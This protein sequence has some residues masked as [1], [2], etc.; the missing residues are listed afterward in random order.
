MAEANSG[1]CNHPTLYSSHSNNN[2]M[3]YLPG[4]VKNSRLLKDKAG[5]SKVG[6]IIGIGLIAAALLGVGS[7]LYLQGG[8]KATTTTSTTIPEYSGP[9]K[10]AIDMSKT[11]ITKAVETC[12]NMRS[13]DDAYCFHYLYKEVAR[14][15]RTSEICEAIPLGCERVK[16]YLKAFS[17]V[18]GAIKDCE[19]LNDKVE[20]CKL[21]VA[22]NANDLNKAEEI[23][24]RTF[25]SKED[26][27]LCLYY[28]RDWYEGLEKIREK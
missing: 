28:V 26:K 21:N 23:C 12:W 8:E 5:I 18:D 19:N 9:F 6:A 22:Y 25:P 11:N 15:N 17:D 2:I 13:P 16:I 10:E 20:M 24:E 1:L 27:E 7:Y 3:N 14:Q 4:F